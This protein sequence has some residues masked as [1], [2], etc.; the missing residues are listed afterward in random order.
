MSESLLPL[1]MRSMLSMPLLRPLPLPV[2]ERLA[3][4]ARP[5]DVAAGT[6]VFAQGD[7]GAGL[8]VI[9]L[10]TVPNPPDTVD[11]TYATDNEQAGK[12]DGQ[13]AAAALNGKPA[14]IAML[15]IIT[16]RRPMVSERCPA[17]GEA[18]KP[19]ACRANMPAPTHRGEKCIT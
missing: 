9:A 8:Y 17:M 7:A 16:L 12:L 4:R 11:I 1:S 5:A 2:I 10:D 15:V 6:P 14:V 18:A 3:Q 13:Y 19:A